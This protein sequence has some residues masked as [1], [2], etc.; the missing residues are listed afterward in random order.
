MT[1]TSKFDL[2]LKNFNHGF[3]LVM[4]AAR[5]LLQDFLIIFYVFLCKSFLD[6]TISFEQVTLTVIFDPIATFE[7]L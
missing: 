1:L 4:V 3:Y 7:Q 2:L 5:L 6:C